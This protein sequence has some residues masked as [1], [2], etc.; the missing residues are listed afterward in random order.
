MKY[1]P[2]QSS[3]KKDPRGVQSQEDANAGTEELKRA[4][5][6][7]N[8]SERISSEKALPQPPLTGTNDI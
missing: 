2:S 6:R 7:E 5:A 3:V 1:C 4:P 8:G